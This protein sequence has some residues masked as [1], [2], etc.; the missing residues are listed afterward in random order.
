MAERV[1][2]V[3]AGPSGL[4][5]A[6]YLHRAGMS[7]LLLER[8]T[9][10]GLVRSANLVENYPGFPGGVTGVD[11]AARFERHLTEVGC[12][13]KKA[14]ARH[15]SVQLDGF[16]TKTD[17]GDFNSHC[18]IIATGTRPKRANLPGGANLVGVKIFDEITDV[19]QAPGRTRQT[20]I[21]GGGD[22]AFDYALNLE[23]RGNEVVIVSRSAPRCL[24]LLRER[25]ERKGVEVHTGAKSISVIEQK[26]GLL[27]SCISGGRRIELRGDWMLR[28]LG[29][30]PNIE[31][32]EP[33]LRRRIGALSGIPE[34]AVPG[35]YLAGDVARASHRQTGIAVGDGIQAAMLAKEY[36]EDKE[37]EE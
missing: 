32:L 31:V 17:V 10:G 9:P 24:P 15:V 35:L 26:D 1:T 20:L 21:L 27:L 4:A 36:L 28:A 12:P 11:L 30:I 22:A 3:G 33:G 2:I 37:V 19:P 14:D 25:A 13:L 23:A 6:I 29:R 7:P 5:A 34:T 16:K 18:V 8:G